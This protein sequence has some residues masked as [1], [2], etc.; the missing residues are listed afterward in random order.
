MPS[1]PCVGV[2][3]RDVPGSATRQRHI[4]SDTNIERYDP[5]FWT[6]EFAFLSFPGMAEIQSDLFYDYRTNVQSYRVWQRWL[7][8]NQPPTLVVWG[9]YDPSFAVAEAEAYK[10]DIP[11]AEVHILDAGHFALDTASN[12]IATLV[13]VFLQKQGRRA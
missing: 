8:R 10:R 7:K 5:D 11:A 3:I 9:R 6:D 2:R 12:E 4:G 1:S 13:K